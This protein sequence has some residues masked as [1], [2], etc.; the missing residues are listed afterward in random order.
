M[1]RIYPII[2]KYDKDPV[3]GISNF[4]KYIINLKLPIK[5][6]KIWGVIC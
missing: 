6:K 1:S 3:A 5:N 4:S 2:I